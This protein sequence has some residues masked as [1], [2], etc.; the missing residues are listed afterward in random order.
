MAAFRQAMQHLIA[1][2]GGYANHPADRGGETWRGIARRRWPNWDGWRIV[3]ARRAEPGFPGIL[4][5]DVRLEAMVADFYHG[6]FWRSEY[7]GLPTQELA[8]K[9]FS[10][11]VLAG[12]GIAMRCLQ[13]ACAAAGNP[14]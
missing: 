14:V 1:E 3:D 12:E 8:N 2:E 4:A 6:E 10:L 9:L 5:G 7:Q 11:A 13:R